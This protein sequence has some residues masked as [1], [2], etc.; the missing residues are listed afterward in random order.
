[1][2]EHGLD[3]LRRVHDL[4]GAVLAPPATGLSDLVLH[5]HGLPV[6]GIKRG[7]QRRGVLL[8]GHHVMRQQLLA[9]HDGVRADGVEGIQGD[10]MPGQRVVLV[11][12]PQQR[13]QFGD[14]VG[15]RATAKAA[16]P[17]CAPRASSAAAGM[18]MRDGAGNGPPGTDGDLG[19][20]SS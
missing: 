4:G 18:G 1:M 11:Q 20:P 2:G 10:D 7:V 9:D 12:L 13:R 8:D 5:G 16:G 19:N 14:L 3:V 17:G 15:L 6:Q